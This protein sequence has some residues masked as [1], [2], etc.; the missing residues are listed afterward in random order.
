MVVT[1]TVLRG[2]FE[3][4]CELRLEATTR[5][6]NLAVAAPHRPAPGT[7]AS[8]LTSG[9]QERELEP[10]FCAKTCAF[11]FRLCCAGQQ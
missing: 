9:S 11:S 2:C 10:D 5:S 4:C 6:S 3:L 8:E 1:L 7:A